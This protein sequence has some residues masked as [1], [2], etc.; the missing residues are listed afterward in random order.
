MSTGAPTRFA[1]ADL[2]T[3]CHDSVDVLAACKALDQADSLKRRLP[4]VAARARAMSGA[5]LY[6][7]ERHTPDRCVTL[8]WTARDGRQ[9]GTGFPI[10]D[11][12]SGT[13][14]DA[15]GLVLRRIGW[16]PLP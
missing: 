2:S 5:N 13:V 16:R 3:W 12:V 10:D 14:R 1:D 7:V 9:W 11:V 8:N 6:M 15:A 4:L